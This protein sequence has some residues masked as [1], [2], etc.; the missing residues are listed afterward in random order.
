MNFREMLERD[1][2][3]V[4]MNPAE[5]ATEH[6]IEGRKLLL[7]EET[8]AE[9]AQRP[10]ARS[11]EIWMLEST[12]RLVFVAEKERVR[13]GLRPFYARQRLLYDGEPMQVLR[14]S[15][16]DGLWTVALAGSTT[17]GVQG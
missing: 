14:C 6:T 9:S 11:E 17:N 2:E 16:S 3:R 15:L 5:L 4:L 13:A 12:D 7:V 10:G 1:L 8:D